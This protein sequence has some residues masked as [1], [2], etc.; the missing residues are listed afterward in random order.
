MLEVMGLLNLHEDMVRLDALTAAR[1]LAAVPFGGK[2]RMIDFVLSNMVNSGI[3]NIGVLM[4]EDSGALIRHLRAGKDWDLD[5]KHEGLFLLL[6]TKRTSLAGTG[7]IDYFSQHLG[8]LLASKYDHV[9]LST[10]QFLC[11][12]NLNLV[13]ERHKAS[14]ADVTL[15]YREMSVTEQRL[16]GSI[17]LGFDN[18]RWVSD[19]EIDPPFS[20]SRNLYMRTAVFRRELLLDI[21]TNAM[22]RGG[23]DY[24]RQ[25]QRRLKDIRMNAWEFTGYVANIADIQAYYKHSMDLLD[26]DVCQDLFYKNGHIYT[27]VKD[28]LP[29]KY[30]SGAEVTNSI[31]ANNCHIDGRVENSVIFRSV[32]VEKNAVVKN[33]VILQDSRIGANVRL[34]NVICDKDVDIS[35]GRVFRGDPE[36]PVVIKK[37]MVV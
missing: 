22:S 33:S 19:M 15:I 6:P 30:M 17:M 11:N 29:T 1:P 27:R 3:K 8:Y 26:Y 10:S 13:F 25:L 14:K 35:A 5:R 2:Y 18:K 16:K 34:E 36:Y 21:I 31:L 4:P 12:V 32:T 23:G 24:V 37:G 28:S 7:D 9:I 20:K